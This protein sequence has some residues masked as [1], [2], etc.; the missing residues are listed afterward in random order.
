MAK[1][2]TKPEQLKRPHEAAWTAWK[3]E[4]ARIEGLRR[5]FAAWAEPWVPAKPNEPPQAKPGWLT[6]I[7]R[8]LANG[9]RGIVH[10]IMNAPG[11]VWEAEPSHVSAPW[12]RYVTASG[13]IRSKPRTRW[14]PV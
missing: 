7:E 4:C 11:R 2:L 12:K 6:K 14:D 9:N 5:E 3:K 1:T 8:D 10:Q 13:E